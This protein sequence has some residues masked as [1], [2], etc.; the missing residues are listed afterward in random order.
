M[1]VAIT[2][3]TKAELEKA[4]EVGAEEII[5]KG[6][7]ADKLKTSKKVA[8]LSGVG[9]VAVTAAFGVATVAAPVTG[10][11]SYFAAPPIAALTGLEIATIITAASLGL[12]FIIALFLGYEEISYKKGLLVLRKKQG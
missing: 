2:V 6:E 12:G 4:K 8:M 9:L 5:V 3:T 7:L 10:G 11:L 1:A